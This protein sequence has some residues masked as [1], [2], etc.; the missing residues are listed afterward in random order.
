MA[1]DAIEIRR[2]R[3][4]DLEALLPLVRGYREFYKRTHDARGE[5]ATMEAHLRDGTSAVYVA[6]DGGVAVGFVQLFHY[7][8]TVCLSPTVILEDLFVAGGA[9]GRGIASSLLERGL[10]YARSVGASE[11]HLETAVDNFVAQ[12]VYER[13]GWT[14]EARFLKYNAPL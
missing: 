2:A 8:S 4:E 13:C 11:V 7:V 5:R 9:R 3:V 1:G 14:R 10:E 12:R 6:W